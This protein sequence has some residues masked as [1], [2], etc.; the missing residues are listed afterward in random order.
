MR[1]EE[2]GSSTFLPFNICNKLSSKDIFGILT[3]FCFRDF[4]VSTSESTTQTSGSSTFPTISDSSSFSSSG[5]L[6]NITFGLDDYN[7]LMT[8]FSN[9]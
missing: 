9:C 8:F 4:G 1:N 3:D 2:T 7:I 5:S 6:D